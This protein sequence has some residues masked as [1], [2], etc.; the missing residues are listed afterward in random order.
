MGPTAE[1]RLQSFGF[2][3][4]GADGFLALHSKLASEVPELLACLWFQRKPT[5]AR[6]EVASSSSVKDAQ[7]KAPVR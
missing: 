7:Q 2:G 5:A 1:I 6:N 3:S 4:V